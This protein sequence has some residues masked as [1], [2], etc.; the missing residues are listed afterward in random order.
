M[1]AS[2]KYSKTPHIAIIDVE[3]NSDD[4]SPNISFEVNDAFLDMIRQE[5]K[6]EKIS[7]ELLSQYVYDLLENCANEKND[8]SYKKS[9]DTEVTIDK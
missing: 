4:S 5:K 8:Y 9:S 3:Y 7:K 6:I 2:H 1:D